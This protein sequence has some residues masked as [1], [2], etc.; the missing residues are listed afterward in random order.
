M[1]C[2]SVLYIPSNEGTYAMPMNKQTIDNI[3]NAVRIAKGINRE[4]DGNITGVQIFI[5]TI[6]LRDYPLK[7]AQFG[8]ENAMMKHKNGAVNMQ[9]IIGATGIASNSCIAAWFDTIEV[10]SL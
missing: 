4:T 10:T 5:E 1:G 6:S 3:R 9:W 2:K 7:K 8:N